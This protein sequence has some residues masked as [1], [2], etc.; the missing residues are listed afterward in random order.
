MAIRHLQDRVEVEINN[1]P[2]PD[3]RSAHSVPG[4]G[5]GLLGIRE[6]TAI[7]GGTVE[8]GSTPGGGFHVAVRLPL[9][10]VPA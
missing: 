3:S 5:Q 10:L 6:R 1:D 4:A 7:F 2:S 9:E 8:A